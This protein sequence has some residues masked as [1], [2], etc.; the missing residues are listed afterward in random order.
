VPNKPALRFKPKNRQTRLVFTSG[1][2]AAM[3]EHHGKVFALI[4]PFD[5]FTDKTD[6]QDMLE[7]LI[8]GHNLESNDP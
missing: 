4:G 5:S 7:C 2:E 3:P 6:L 1:P 8:R